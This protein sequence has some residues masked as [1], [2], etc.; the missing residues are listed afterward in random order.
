MA[1]TISSVTLFTL[2]V[3]QLTQSGKV[4]SYLG[5]EG[6]AYPVDT[7]MYQTEPDPND[8]DS[9]FRFAFQF[10][11]TAD[12]A[13]T[14]KYYDGALSCD[15]SPDLTMSHYYCMEPPDIT[16]HECQCIGRGDA[17]DT[18]TITISGGEECEAYEH[19]KTD[20][21]VN[22][23]VATGRGGAEYF[24]C[25]EDKLYL[26]EYLNEDCSGN[27]VIT[28]WDYDYLKDNACFEVLCNS[29]SRHRQL[30]EERGIKAQQNKILVEEYGF[31]GGVNNLPD[32]FAFIDEHVRNHHLFIQNIISQHEPSI[33]AK[34][35]NKND[36]FGND[37]IWKHEALLLGVASVVLVVCAMGLVIYKRNSEYVKI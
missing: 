28:S 16:G 30:C 1:F 22:E 26:E 33:I 2:F 24:T 10:A 27:A 36:I 15:G 13:M 4:C 14:A 29:G 19:Q 6:I 8:A 25:D 35:A 34:H 11:C 20:V 7:C 9:T 21:V 12:G 17:C 23:C 32:D 5:I 37:A 18:F 31:V 3:L